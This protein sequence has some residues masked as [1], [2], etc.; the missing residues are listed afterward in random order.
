MWKEVEVLDADFLRF[1]THF[2]GGNSFQAS[3]LTYHVLPTKFELIEMLKE[4]V[5]L[6]PD[7]L[8]LDTRFFEAKSFQFFELFFP[9]FSYHFIVVWVRPPFTSELRKI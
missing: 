3:R 4:A 7:F 1:N 2:F 9:P 5:V 8:R 6:D